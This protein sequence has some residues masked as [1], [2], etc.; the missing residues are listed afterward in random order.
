[1]NSMRLRP[2]PRLVSVPVRRMRL[3]AARLR[4]IRMLPRVGPRR[5]GVRTILHL[6]RDRRLVNHTLHRP[7][8]IPLTETS[9]LPLALRLAIST[10]HLLGRLPP[11]HRV[12]THRRPALRRPIRTTPR[13]LLVL[14][15]H[16]RSRSMTGRPPFRTRP[17]FPR[18]PLSSAVGIGRRPTTLRSR[19]PRRARNG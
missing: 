4:L 3:R 7:A 13:R 16:S 10:H 11:I 19:R 8:R 9:H 1:M 2:D 14:H 17:C 15:R 12:T 5:A 6:R 18:R